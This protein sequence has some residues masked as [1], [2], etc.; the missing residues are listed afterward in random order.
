MRKL[1]TLR[2]TLCEE[3][4]K[5]AKK[6]NISTEDLN[7]I[8]KL[9]HSIKNIDKIMQDESYDGGYY[10]GS[11]DRGSY[12]SYDSYARRG[13]DG[14]GDGRRGEGRS[15][16]RAYGRSRDAERMRDKLSRMMGEASNDKERDTL[17]R[18]MDQLDSI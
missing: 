7:V 11:Y 9:A 4:E 10:F 16:S 13:R 18:V 2:D 3:L 8:D 15:R 5:V 17:M 14:D 12:D 1:E 6:E